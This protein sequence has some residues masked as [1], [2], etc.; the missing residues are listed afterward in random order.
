MKVFGGTEPILSRLG[1]AR[2]RTSNNPANKRFGWLDSCSM[3]GMRKQTSADWGM[4]IE[5]ALWHLQRNTT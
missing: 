2:E 3:F 1:T 4:Y 5:V